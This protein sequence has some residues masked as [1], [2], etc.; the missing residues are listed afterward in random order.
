MPELIAK[1][2]KKL[3]AIRPLK[4]NYTRMLGIGYKSDDILTLSA[5]K[6]IKFAQD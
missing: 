5:K 6:F 3:V 1:D 4:P 2:Y